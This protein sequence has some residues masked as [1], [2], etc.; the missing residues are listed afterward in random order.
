ME[1]LYSK[2]GILINTTNY[3]ILSRYTAMHPLYTRLY[4]DF[5]F[6]HYPTY[7]QLASTAPL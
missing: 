1:N 6:T 4:S 2:S 5:Q 3:Y 7:Q